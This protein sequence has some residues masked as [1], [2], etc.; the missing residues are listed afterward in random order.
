MKQYV[1]LPIAIIAMQVAIIAM[2]VLAG[3]SLAE[4]DNIGALADFTGKCTKFEGKSEIKDYCEDTVHNFR[5]MAGYDSFQFRTPAKSNDDQDC[6][7]IA[8]VGSQWGNNK[9]QKG[10]EKLGDNMT[11]MTIKQ[12]I[13]SNVAH[14]FQEGK[15][16]RG[17]CVFVFKTAESRAGSDVTKIWCEYEDEHHGGHAF[18]L[19]DVTN[20]ELHRVMNFSDYGPL[21]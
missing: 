1:I 20:F 16:Y 13:F 3:A 7:V 18:A 5:F 14:H 21:K 8:F 17:Q 4:T 11:F 6:D 9:D 19:E 15:Q 10:A 12:V 2:Q